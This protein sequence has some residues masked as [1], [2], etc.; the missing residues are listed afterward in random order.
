MMDGTHRKAETSMISALSLLQT[1]FR[2]KQTAIL[3]IPSLC[4]FLNLPNLSNFKSS[5]Q[6]F[7]YF[8]TWDNGKSK[9]LKVSVVFWHH[10]IVTL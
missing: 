6:Y 5:R 9:E 4:R 2:I 8:L 3:L 1:T 10:L 7:E